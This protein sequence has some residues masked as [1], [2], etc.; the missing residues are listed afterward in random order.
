MDHAG[1]DAAEHAGYLGY[2]LAP[3]RHSV[4]ADA[5]PLAQSAVRRLQL[6]LELFN[7]FEVGRKARCG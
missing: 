5:L 3:D 6:L 2:E 4:G 1:N 7:I